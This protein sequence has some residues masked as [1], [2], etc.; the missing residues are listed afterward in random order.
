MVVKYSNRCLCELTFYYL[1]D[2]RSVLLPE[3]LES[4][5]VSWKNRV[6]QKSLSLIIVNYDVPSLDSNDENL[7]I[8]E[9]YIGLGIIKNFKVTDFKDK[10]YN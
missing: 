8:I 7:D 6:P 10:M 4:C 9:K 1:Y 2:V 3:E 5:L